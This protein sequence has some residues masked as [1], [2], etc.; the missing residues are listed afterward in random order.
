M[1]YVH[2]RAEVEKLFVRP[3]E[4]PQ[5]HSAFNLIANARCMLLVPLQLARLATTIWAEGRSYGQETFEGAARVFASPPLPLVLLLMA[6]LIAIAGTQQW[7]A[8]QRPLPDCRC[9]LVTSADPIRQP[10]RA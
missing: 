6:A 5:A 2:R 4:C 1:G 7:S 10:L 9:L 8:K 3:Q